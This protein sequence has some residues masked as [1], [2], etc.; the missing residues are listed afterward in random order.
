MTTPLPTELSGLPPHVA[1]PLSPSERASLPDL[2]WQAHA[3][4]PLPPSLKVVFDQGHLTAK[5]ASGQWHIGAQRARA[6]VDIRFTLD[7][8]EDKEEF[9]A[10]MEATRDA[11]PTTLEWYAAFNRYS[12]QELGRAGNQAWAKTA[13]EALRK[14]PL[15]EDLETE[16][17]E[18][19]FEYRYTVEGSGQPVRIYH[20]DLGK[21]HFLQLNLSPISASLGVEKEGSGCSDLIVMF[22][23]NDRTQDD[24]WV[25][26]LWPEVVANPAQSIALAALEMCKAFERDWSPQPKKKPKP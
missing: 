22:Y 20:K 1:R 4:P 3:P 15:V 8:P 26:R 11:E 16:V 10:M 17:R 18:A 9:K 14:K 7:W 6:D 23:T 19:G 13:V 2:E 5:D 24:R 25:P 12:Q 21:T